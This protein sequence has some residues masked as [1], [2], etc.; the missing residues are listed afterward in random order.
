MVPGHGRVRI[1]AAGL[2]GRPAKA[3]AFAV[4]ILRKLTHAT[5]AVPFGFEPVTTNV[6]GKS[7]GS[8]VQA[9]NAPPALL[10]NETA[11]F[12]V[13][14]R[15]AAGTNAFG[16][17]G[18]FATMAVPARRAILRSVLAVK[19]SAN[20]RLASKHGLVMH[21]A[22]GMI[23]GHVVMRSAHDKKFVATPSM[24]IAMAMIYETPTGM[25]HRVLTTSVPTAHI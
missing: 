22:A 8:V 10:K 23:L 9:D 4:Q 25:T 3:K 5:P 2:S 13:A 24:K 16:G 1:V 21:N 7:M 19:I 20:V 12:V 17:I 6:N 11:V 18:A 15:G 14:S